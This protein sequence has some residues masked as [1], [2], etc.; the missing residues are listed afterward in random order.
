MKDTMEDGI[1]KHITSILIAIIIAGIIAG[2]GMVENNNTNNRV[3]EEQLKF[4]NVSMLNLQNDVSA[5][6]VIIN[7]NAADRW[8]K[9]DQDRHQDE[10]NIRLDKMN[11][12]L[13]ELERDRRNN[14][15]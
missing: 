5:L 7:G 14:K 3:L 11:D 4:M 13:L 8:R 1:K 2:I 9:A 10:M 6:K 15:N 12:R